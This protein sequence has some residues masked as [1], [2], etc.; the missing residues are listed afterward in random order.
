MT[1][2]GPGGILPASSELAHRPPWWEPVR[3][4]ARSANRSPERLRENWL[5][6]R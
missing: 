3:G 6:K 5:N 2:E 1:S 4:V